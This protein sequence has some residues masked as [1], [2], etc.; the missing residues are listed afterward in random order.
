MTG[1]ANSDLKGFDLQKSMSMVTSFFG[2]Q[3]NLNGVLNNQNGNIDLQNVMSTL[4]QSIPANLNQDNDKPN[5]QQD[6]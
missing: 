5:E 4:M 3:N 6:P 2:N 1:G